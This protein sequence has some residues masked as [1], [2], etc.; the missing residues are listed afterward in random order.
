MKKQVSETQQPVQAGQV[1]KT[2]VKRTRKAAKASEPATQENTLPV[3]E[4]PEAKQPTEQQ[5]EE[6]KAKKVVDI[7]IDRK[8]LENQTEKAILLLISEGEKHT[9]VWLPKSQVNVIVDA[10]D[11][12]YIIVRIAGWLWYRQNLGSIFKAERW[13]TEAV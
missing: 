9:K 5:P 12:D 11:T 4:Q 3:E 6:K 2:V 7:R 13:A 10:D 8:T 1:A